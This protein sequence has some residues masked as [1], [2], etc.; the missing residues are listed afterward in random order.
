GCN[1]EREFNNSRADSIAPA[2]T[3]TILPWTVCR[4]VSPAALSRYDTPM[5][6]PRSSVSM[7]SAIVDVLSSQFPVASARGITVFCVPLLASVGHAKP[8]QYLQ[9]IHDDRPP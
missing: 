6:L 5:T 1:E 3:I 7:S 9:P 4:R 8:T 2:E